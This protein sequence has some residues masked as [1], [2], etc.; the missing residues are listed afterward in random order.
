MSGMTSDAD[1][2]AAARERV[3]ALRAA[4]ERREGQ[5][6][7][8]IETHI[9]WV[10]LAGDHAYKLKKPL[11]LP[12]LDFTSLASRRHFC[13][14]ELRINRRLAPSLYLDVI[15]IREGPAGPDFGPGDG[16]VRDVA[17]Q[18]RRFPDGAL[19]SEMLAAG[20]LHGTHVDAFARRLS[21]FHAAAD[22]A[23]NGS[24]FGSTAVNLRVTRGLID[25]FDARFVALGSTGSEWPALR[26]WL[27]RQS[28]ALGTWWD[29]RRQAGRVREC[30]GDLH[31]ANV[32]QLD[33]EA[34]A[35]DAIEFDPE[36]RWIDVANDTAFLA[37]D[38][39][40]H[41]R[42]RLAFGFINAYLEESGEFDGLAGLRFYMVCRALVRAQVAAIGRP[43][44]L[45]PVGGCGA[46]AYL[47]LAARLARGDELR[48]AITHGLPGSGKSHVSR[49]VSE[50][51]GA[52]R[53]RSDV[54]RKRLF[55]LGALDSSRSLGGAG[56]YDAAS[57]HRTYSRLL[58]LARGTLSA[59]WPVIVDA[60][61]LR[62]AERAE[63]AALA[64]ALAVPFSIVDCRADASVLRQRIEQ[65]GSGSDASEADLP[66]LEALTEAAEPL[67]ADEQDAV[68]L[69][70]AAR[71][72]APESIAQRWLAATRHS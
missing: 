27:A 10:L 4:L 19:W 24:T 72:V 50:T 22:V 26:A 5:P 25:A 63:F 6:V 43:A 34:T 53:L 69:V 64:E 71:P 47:A 55:G 7:K 68:I 15:D 49:D 58:E 36:L 51:A 16:P 57:T 31:L 40:A 46:D 11:R 12:F 41:G 13:A 45:D 1:S 62:R 56:I 20:K 61:F 60:A 48:L 17:V 18:M 32:L 39:L 52:I 65:R 14:E 70:D 28:G 59:G 21:Q 23:P 66:V 30:H 54:E 33:G 42:R 38:L 67:E 2:L 29:A 37:M 3:A 44:G 35:F 8:L 9:S